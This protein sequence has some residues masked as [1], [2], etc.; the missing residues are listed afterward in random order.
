VSRISEE[1]H[2]YQALLRRY[3]KVYNPEANEKAQADEREANQRRDRFLAL[4]EKPPA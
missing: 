3:G 4:F 1:D 2:F